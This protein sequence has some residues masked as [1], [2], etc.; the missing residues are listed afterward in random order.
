MVKVVV[1]MVSVVLNSSISLS[2]RGPR[3]QSGLD[4]AVLASFVWA[5]TLA[6]PLIVWEADVTIWNHVS[7]D[8]D[9]VWLECA[10]PAACTA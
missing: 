6:E 10:Y 3:R 4:S 2:S 1:R 7:I 5:L 9:S 8:R